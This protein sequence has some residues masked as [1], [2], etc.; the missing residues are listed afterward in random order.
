MSTRFDGIS[1]TLSSLVTLVKRQGARLASLEENVS[2]LRRVV[3]DRHA[4]DDAAYAELGHDPLFSLPHLLHDG[5]VAHNTVSRDSASTAESGSSFEA[6]PFRAS[7]V[8]ASIHKYRPHDRYHHEPLAGSPMMPTA[9]SSEPLQSSL[10]VLQAGSSALRS[11]NPDLRGLT[12]SSSSLSFDAMH[13]GGSGSP[14]S[15]TQFN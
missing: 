6:S 11:S 15:T 13:A 2:S 3:E 9:S 4:K 14:G 7:Q 12:L 10:T 5:E 8:V 1:Q